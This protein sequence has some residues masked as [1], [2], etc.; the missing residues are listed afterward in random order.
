MPS[1]HPINREIFRMLAEMFDLVDEQL[2][3]ATNALVLGDTSLVDGVLSL[4]KQVDQLELDIDLACQHLLADSS[5]PLAVVQELLAAI[6]IN[7]E[8]ERIGD[9]C[10]NVSKAVYVLPPVELWLEESD[11]RTVAD[12]VR[13]VLR[14]LHKAFM[15]RDRLMAWQVLALDLQ[16]DRAW[17]KIPLSVSNLCQRNP[18]HIGAL[19]HILLVGKNLERIADH[20]KSIARSLIYAIDGKDVRHPDPQPTLLGVPTSALP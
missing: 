19:I 6:Q 20:A 18:D 4:D 5:R 13:Q 15:R 2:A 1:T 11:M 17:R 10:K 9:L 14:L 3:N 16:V 12:A 8:L 7:G